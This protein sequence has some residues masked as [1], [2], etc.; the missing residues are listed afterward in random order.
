M[1]F[2]RHYTRDS[3]AYFKPVR[4]GIDPVNDIRFELFFLF[5][6]DCEEAIY[7]ILQQPVD[8]HWYDRYGECQYQFIHYVDEFYPLHPQVWPPLDQTVFNLDMGK[9]V[10]NLS[11]R[12][13]SKFVR[14][15]FESTLKAKPVTVSNLDSL[16][17]ELRWFNDEQS[18]PKLYDQLKQ[19]LNSKDTYCY[20]SVLLENGIWKVQFIN[21]QIRIILLNRRNMMCFKL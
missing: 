17:A 18:K 15:L 5:K 6:E 14:T 8:G 10:R 9:A 1:P 7:L 21:D 13:K 2:F 12:D 3:V 16:F 4:I 19:A 11:I 20:S